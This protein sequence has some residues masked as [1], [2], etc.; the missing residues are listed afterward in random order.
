MDSKV[1]PRLESKVVS[2]VDSKLDSTSGFA[3]PDFRIL[4]SYGRTGWA[5]SNGTGVSGICW[6]G[7]QPYSGSKVS[8]PQ[9]DFWFEDFDVLFRVQDLGIRV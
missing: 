3:N 7:S 5:P 2:S 4:D 9:P 6:G 1:D 8:M